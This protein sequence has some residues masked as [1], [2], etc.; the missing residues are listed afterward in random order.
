MATM[1]N[2]TPTYRP[3]IGLA[4]GSGLARGWA[5]LGVLRALERYGFKPDLLAGTSIGA[6]VGGSYLAGRVEAWEAWARTLNNVRMISYLDLRVRGGGMIGG[7]HLIRAMEK[8]MGDILIEDLETPFVAVATDMVTGHEV[9][10]REGR[11]VETI[12]SS[13]SL[14]GV[15]EPVRY[16]GR[17]LV[18]GALVNPVPV[19][20]CQALGAQLTIAVNLNADLLGKERRGE[21]GIPNG[22]GF[23]LLQE[24]KAGQ[25]SGEGSRL[26]ALTRRVFRRA[27]SKPSIFGV[28]IS[29]LSIVQDR[30][31]RS[32]L[33]GEPP[34]VHITPRLGHIG[35]FEFDRADEV[36]AEGEAAVERALPDL[37]DALAVF[38]YEP[39]DN[40]ND[41]NG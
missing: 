26:S 34:D 1:E 2:Q 7:R 30:I 24:L 37:V 35:L 20:V 10:L 17:W 19:S 15:F 18:D 23:D 40:G 33:A 6:V 16:K 41:R 28:M 25:G 14:P 22:A 32:R 5:H 9:W 27:P 13:F 29:S 3:K 31:T 4:L 39:T 38:G 36:I 11:L 21:S 8:E 12:R